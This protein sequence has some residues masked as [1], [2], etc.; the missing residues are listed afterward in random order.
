MRHRCLHY[1]CHESGQVLCVQSARL[2]GARAELR[3]IAGILETHFGICYTQETPAILRRLF[4]KGEVQLMRLPFAIVLSAASFALSLNSQTNQPSSA[5]PEATLH[6]NSRAVLVDVLVTDRDGHPVKGLKRDA[7][8]VNEQ[9]KPQSISF[10]EEHTAAPPGPPRE[11]PKLPP[12]VFSNLS[13]FPEPPAVNL[14]LLDSLNTHMENQQ[15]VHKQALRFLKSAKPGTRMAVFTMGL[16]LHFV[17][18]FTDDP[19]LLLAALN[20]KVNN[21]VQPSQPDQADAESAVNS[22]LIGMMSAPVA[23]GGG[24]VSSAP[25]AMI[26]GLSNFLGENAAS[27]QTDEVLL[28]MKNMQRLAMFLTG[29][30]GRKNVI[31][32]SES[33][34]LITPNG[35]GSSGSSVDPQR[36][37]MYAKTMA[38][39][40]AA[41]VALYPVDS[42]GTDSPGFYQAGNNLAASTA[43]PYQIMG[44]DN[45]PTGKAGG[46]SPGSHA[47]SLQQEDQDR[48]TARY[49]EEEMAKETGG[50]AFIGTN[51]LAEV[52]DDITSSSADFYTIS[53]VPE[54]QKMDGTF[55]KI[56][57]KVAGGHY[58]LSYRR[59]YPATDEAL[60]GSA[61]VARARETEQLA[62]KNPGAVDPLLPFMDLGMPQSQQV[63]FKIL[64]KPLPDKPATEAS[65]ATPPATANPAQPAAPVPPTDATPTTNPDPKKPLPIR[66]K[67]DFAIDLSDLT[68]DVDTDG[69]HKGALNLSILAYDRYGNIVGRRDSQASLAIKPEIWEIYKKTGLL[70]S[71]EIQVPKGHYWMRVGLFDQGSR[72]VGTLELPLDAVTTVA[73]R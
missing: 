48:A 68:L 44:V 38:M 63:L 53:Y 28:T 37:D 8:T 23:T 61:F 67:V 7:F 71:T 18:G 12:N 51:G 50:K 73:Q 35:G 22:T 4:R 34:P 39:L 6:I 72:K 32:F 3:T 54:N 11:M 42:R 43:A 33:F 13:P 55:R 19:T 40:A 46:S 58:N 59:G 27:R 17:Q 62:A 49:T 21:E 64:V 1:P 9:G 30:P 2:P 24:V 57:V 26:A 69:L 10:F 31:W 66:Y 15:F 5:A 56:D 41:R 52:I 65:Q 14:L 20:R 60:P 36:S 70:F 25:A 16:G 29:F 47:G 45:A